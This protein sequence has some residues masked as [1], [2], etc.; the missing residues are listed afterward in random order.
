MSIPKALRNSKKV[1]LSLLAICAFL[2]LFNCSAFKMVS[3][4]YKDSIDENNGFSSILFFRVRLI[5]KFPRNDIDKNMQSKVPFNGV[6]FGVSD[7]SVPEYIFNE[8][9][10]ES[11][12]TDSSCNYEALFIAQAK[13]NKY[14]LRTVALPATIGMLGS[15]A[16]N[17]LIIHRIFDVSPDKLLY[18]GTIQIDIDYTKQNDATITRRADGSFASS[19][20]ATKVSSC[21]D[22]FKLDTDLFKSQYPLLFQRFENKLDT[23]LLK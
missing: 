6:Y 17:T 14:I 9:G 20:K 3:D 23:V 15:T 4:L 21:F 11:I 22:S 5:E 8:I 1:I 2:P 18:L 12:K 19:T 13:A 16:S 7:S 10:A